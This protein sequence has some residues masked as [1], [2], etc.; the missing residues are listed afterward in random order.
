MKDEGCP[1]EAIPYDWVALTMAAMAK[2]IATTTEGFQ[3]VGYLLNGCEI[4]RG[5]DGDHYELVDDEKNEVRTIKSEDIVF[6][7]GVVVEGKP[8]SRLN[9]MI[10][11]KP[12]NQC[13]DCGIIS[14]CLTKDEVLDTYSGQ[15]KRLC[16][17]CLTYSDNPR[18]R[19]LGCNAMCGKCTVTAC[20]HHQSREAK[21]S[22]GGL[23]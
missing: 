6:Y 2:W 17:H 3:S 22:Y 13:D 4:K 14:H 8:T 12:K 16:N 20:V 19:D 1:H 11:D 23:R 18:L 10:S 9:L 15:F 5:H 7:S 21:H